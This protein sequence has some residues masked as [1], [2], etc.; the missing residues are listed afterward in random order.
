MDISA[1]DELTITKSNKSYHFKV[2]QFNNVVRETEQNVKIMT[3][4]DFYQWFRSNSKEITHVSIN[5][6][7]QH[8]S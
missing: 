2:T 4:Q 6:C 7:Q 5:H 3:L 8:R 1:G